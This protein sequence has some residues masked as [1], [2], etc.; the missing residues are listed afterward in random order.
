MRG[1]S[2]GKRFSKSSKEQT[3][4]DND[5]TYAIRYR[6]II[7]GRQIQGL[8]C[9]CGT[10]TLEDENPFGSNLPNSLS[11][12]RGLSVLHR[13]LSRC[14][15][16]PAICGAQYRILLQC[17][18]HLPLPNALYIVASLSTKNLVLFAQPPAL[19][20]ALRGKVTPK[21]QIGRPPGASAPDGSWGEN[22][23]GNRPHRS[24]AVRASGL[25]L[26]RPG[27]PPGRRQRRVPAAAARSRS[28][29]PRRSEPRGREMW[30]LPPPVWRTFRPSRTRTCFGRAHKFPDPYFV[31]RV[32]SVALLWDVSTGNWV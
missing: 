28:E 20:S 7:P 22:L 23:C 12:L 18:S 32:C 26:S 9:V 31:N 25:G 29:G 2:L 21:Q 5:F 3:Q 30:R 16:E 24:A 6:L 1:P 10:L 11:L 8:P 13:M 17:T 19:L 4:Q 27:T 14:I 15:I